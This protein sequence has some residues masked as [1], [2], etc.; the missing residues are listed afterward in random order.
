MLFRARSLRPL[1]RV[2]SVLFASAA[3]AALGLCAV[4][5]ARTEAAAPRA[6]AASAQSNIYSGYSRIG[7]VSRSYGARVNIYDGYSR[8]GYLSRAF[9]GRWNV[10]ADYSRVGY[11]KSSYGGRWDIYEGYSKIG[12]VKRAY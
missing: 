6:M 5:S 1:S 7:Y 10:Y 11:V 12:Y 9:N 2:A 8:A 4:T 3:L